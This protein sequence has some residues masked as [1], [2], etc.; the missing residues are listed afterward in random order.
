MR[1]C[2][3]SAVNS[4]FNHICLLFHS[5]HGKLFDKALLHISHEVS[6]VIKVDRG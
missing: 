4:K 6:P 2:D 5:I 1:E 3:T